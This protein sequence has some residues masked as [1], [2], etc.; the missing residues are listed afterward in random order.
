MSECRWWFEQKK[1]KEFSWNVT[2][3]TRKIR[4][5]YKHQLDTLIAI[6]YW[7]KINKTFILLQ[8]FGVNWIYADFQFE[9]SSWKGVR[10]GGTHYTKSVEINN[11]TI[12][13][14]RENQAIVIFRVEIMLL[15]YC[16]CHFTMW[17]IKYRYVDLLLEWT[18]G[19]ERKCI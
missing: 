7:L 11:I 1:K 15:K 14:N 13:F 2:G 3:L 19:R 18:R 12:T 16:L 10:R 4:R 5:K 9:K 6:N 17:T 8:I